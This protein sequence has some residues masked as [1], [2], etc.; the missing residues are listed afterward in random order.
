MERMTSVAGLGIA[1][2]AKPKVVANAKQLG[3]GNAAAN[4]TAK[5]GK[6]DW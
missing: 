4:A 3:H 2:H 6:R 5:G 1:F